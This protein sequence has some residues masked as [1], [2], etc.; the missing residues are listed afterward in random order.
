MCCLSVL[1]RRKPLC[2]HMHLNAGSQHN[3]NIAT[4]DASLICRWGSRKE[5]GYA[6]WCSKENS[7]N[8]RQRHECEIHRRSTHQHRT[9]GIDTVSKHQSPQNIL[10]KNHCTSSG[11][12]SHAVVSSYALSLV[13][14]LVGH[15]VKFMFAH[16]IISSIENRAFFL[17]DY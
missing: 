15:I 11:Y 8:A 3:Q 9:R 13:F 5:K 12:N 17:L 16:E 1:D 14:L 6:S 2:L 4:S 10:S 7:I